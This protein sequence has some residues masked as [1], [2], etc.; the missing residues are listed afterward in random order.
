M[1]IKSIKKTLIKTSR[2]TS[3]VN[4]CVK[5]RQR[6]DKK[7][8]FWK[9]NKIHCDFI[10]INIERSFKSHWWGHVVND[11]SNNCVFSF[12]T[13]PWTFWW[14]DSFWFFCERIFSNFSFFYLSINSFNNFIQLLVLNRQDTISCINQTIQCHHTIIRSYINIISFWTW[15]DTSWKSK[16]GSVMI[17]N[18]L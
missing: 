5:R 3:F 11:M 8:Q 18:W 1:R 2:L 12:K 10:H 14:A 9:R 4:D 7:F 6:T 13:W 16:I 15:K 17:S